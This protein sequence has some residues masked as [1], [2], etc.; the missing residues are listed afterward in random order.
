MRYLRYLVL[1]SIFV[2]P[3]V[4]SQA[5]VAV[6][7]GVGSVRL[8]AMS[9]P[10]RHALMDTIPIIRTH[11]RLMVITVRNGLWEACSL[12]PAPGI[13]DGMARTVITDMAHTAMV[14]DIMAVDTMVADTTGRAPMHTV[15]ELVTHMVACYARGGFAHGG[16][17]LP[18]W[19]RTSLT[20][21]D[22]LA[23]SGWQRVCQPFC[24]LVTRPSNRSCT[25]NILD[26]PW[27][28]L[29]PC[30]VALMWEATTKSA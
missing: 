24:F 30:F 7:V 4:Q 28:C 8:T 15:A 21:P 6:G 3:A 5:A 2:V 9:V 26:S 18:W 17:R 29:F 14:A 25:V 1:L 22:K 19:W 16:Q 11:A 12:A 20:F 13:T 10:H 23:E 27:P